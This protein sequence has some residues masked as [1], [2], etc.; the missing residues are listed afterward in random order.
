MDITPVIIIIVVVV[1]D[2]L[3]TCSSAGKVRWKTKADLSS[4]M[5]IGLSQPE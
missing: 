2:T 5:S 1:I 4:P 3:V